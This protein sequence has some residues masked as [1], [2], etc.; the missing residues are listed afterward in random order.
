MRVRDGVILSGIP[1][2]RGP[3]HR[4]PV[5]IRTDTMSS[6]E[7]Y[8]RELH[9]SSS[10]L[11]VFTHCSHQRGLLLA[12]TYLHANIPGLCDEVMLFIH[13]E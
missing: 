4:E 5:C 6:N 8:A 9:V 11:S 12:V 7:E 2:T 13:R 10:K 1:Q 3:A